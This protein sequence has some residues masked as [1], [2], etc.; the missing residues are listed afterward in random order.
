MVKEDKSTWKA[1]YFIKIIQ[2]LN[3]YPKC[4]IVKADNVGSRQMQT[5]RMSLR[6]H[7]VVLMG[8]NH[9]DEEGHKRLL[10]HIKNN[11]GFVFTLADIR[12]RLTNNKVK[13]PALV[14]AVSPSLSIPTKISSGPIE[15]L[16]DVRNIV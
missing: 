9:N 14:G 4:F 10:S 8:K 1:N 2:L 5:F 11:V 3:E 15:I 12:D 6:G 13:T 16:N 7:A